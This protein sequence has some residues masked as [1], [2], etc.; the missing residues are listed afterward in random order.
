MKRESSVQGFTLLELLVVI[1]IIGILAAVL[2]PSL[3]ASRKR[4]YD[5]AA[6]GCA[7][8]IQTLQAISWVDIKQYMVVGGAANQIN[9][10]TEGVDSSCKDTNMYFVDRSNAG[11]LGNNYI[12]DVWDKRGTSVMTVT[13]NS[14]Q[15][16]APGA[17][18]FSNTGAGGNNLP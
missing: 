17:T 2:I 7:K 4:A 11:A 15:A 10:N 1:V 18:P 9:T 16:N 13:P 8:S 3:N 12:I 5:A 14:L 6:R